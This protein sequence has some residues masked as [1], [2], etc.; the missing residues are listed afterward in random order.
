ML[1][2]DVP[3]NLNSI[4]R[5]SWTVVALSQL[6]SIIDTNPSLYLDEIRSMLKKSTNK[7]FSLSSICRAIKVRLKY[8]R[9]VMY[10]KASQQALREKDDFI[11]IL[12][13]YLSTPEMAIFVDESNKDR[14]EGS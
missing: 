13:Q 4:I 14:A 3:R 1:L 9:K 12:T 7:T 10:E 8:S 6:K 11:A 2:C 5:S